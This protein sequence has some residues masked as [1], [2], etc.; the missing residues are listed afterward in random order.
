MILLI[1]F[2]VVLQ[3]LYVQLSETSLQPLTVDKQATYR[4]KYSTSAPENITINAPM[5]RARVLLYP[6]G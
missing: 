5:V 6:L 4:T 2:V 3:F 1:I